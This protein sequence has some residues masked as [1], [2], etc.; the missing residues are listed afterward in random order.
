MMRVEARVDQGQLR[1]RDEV[2]PPAVGEVQGRAQWP[3]GAAIWQCERARRPFRQVQR[4][5]AT[6]AHGA[7]PAALASAPP[8]RPQALQLHDVSVRDRSLG[9]L[10]AYHPFWLKIGL[11]VVTQR[12]VGG[13]SS[14]RGACGVGDT[15][16]GAAPDAVQTC[17]WAVCQAGRRL[18]PPCRALPAPPAPRAQARTH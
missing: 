11:E 1:L 2:R 3:A 9:V 15:G 16:G 8:R 4:V 13:G 10:M 17:C 12:S 6:A 18:A 5:A 7:C 14:G